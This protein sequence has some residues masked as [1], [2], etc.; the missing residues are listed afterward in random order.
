[1]TDWRITPPAPPRLEFAL[2][3]RLKLRK[4]RLHIDT[5]PQSG[6]RLSVSIESGTF[7][8]PTLSGTVLTGG[9]E[10]PHVR[11]D[12]VFCF[13]AR[14][15][16]QCD[17]GSI[18]LLINQGYRHADPEVQQRLWKLA[19]GDEVPPD[20]Y[21]LRTMTKFETGPGPHEWMTKHVFVGVGERTDEGNIIRYFKLC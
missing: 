19:P 3:V 14:Y 20:A 16:L 11:E 15:Q 13:D 10:W 12:D 2:E 9:G 5:L 8:G 6:K 4:P 7:S 1:M 17:D 21:Y 18:I